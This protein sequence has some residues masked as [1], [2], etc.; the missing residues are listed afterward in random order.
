MDVAR[1]A[2]QTVRA[3][4]TPGRI[5]YSN[6]SAWR[7]AA[8]YWGGVLKPGAKAAWNYVGSPRFFVTKQLGQAGWHALEDGNF[9]RASGDLGGAYAWSG[10]FIPGMGYELYRG[11][12]EPY[13]E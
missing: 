6:P 7:T 5:N 9:D 11:I 10:G 12:S 2:A 8:N 13:A 1:P 3:M 4:M